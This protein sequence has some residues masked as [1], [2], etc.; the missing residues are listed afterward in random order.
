[1]KRIHIPVNSTRL[2]SAIGVRAARAGVV[3]H[4]VIKPNFTAG[5]FGKL[6][7]PLKKA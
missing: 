5:A 4:K 2:A 6:F 1:M 7:H 3:T